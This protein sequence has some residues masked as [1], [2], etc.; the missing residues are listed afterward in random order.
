MRTWKA[1]AT[2]P[3]KTRIET[4]KANPTCTE[5]KSTIASE[6][7]L[8]QK[9]KTRKKSQETH[10][11]TKISTALPTSLTTTKTTL[12]MRLIWHPRHIST[13]LS[14]EIFPV[15]LWTGASP[16]LQMFLSPLSK[17]SWRNGLAVWT[18]LRIGTTQWA[19]GY[20][21]TFYTSINVKNKWSWRRCTYYRTV[22]VWS[23][24]I[25]AELL[26]NS[27]LS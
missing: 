5:E 21:T 9:T 25:N 11:T 27:Q 23:T 24:R 16:P 6:T 8:K 7:R 15:K 13:K 22:A 12:S 17:V 4:V 26:T 20:T 3:T 18:C 2:C 19:I 1:R 10:P 14:L